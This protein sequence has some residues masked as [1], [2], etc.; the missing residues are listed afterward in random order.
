MN[1]R[2]KILAGAFGLA[3]GAVVIFLAVNTLFLEPAA[4]CDR[5]AVQEEEKIARIEAQYAR[6]D[7]YAAHLKEMAAAAFGAEE[8]R[9]AQVRMRVLEQVRTTVDRLLTLSGLSTQNLV[10]TP[11]DGAAVGGAYREI[12]W[13]VVAQGKLGQVINFLYLMSREPHLH[14]LDNIS[15]KPLAG[16]PG[17]VQLQV[18]YATLILALAKGEKLDIDALPEAPL[19]S[20]AL[21]APDRQQYEIIAARALF[22]PFIPR[23]AA[24]A[25]RPPESGG[26]E[27]RPQPPGLCLVS[28]A[29]Y[30]GQ[31]D[32][33]V[34]DSS[35]GKMAYYKLGD[36][37]A[38]GKIM[39]VDYR[40]LPSP[41]D[42]EVL[43]GSRLILRIGA[44][45]YAIEL[46]Q[47]LSQKRP[48]PAADL[49]P[50]L[51]KLQTVDP[52]P[53]SAPAGPETK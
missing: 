14:R 39:M 34:R 4:K 38:G 27:T 10:L 13:N 17:N 12:N 20:S 44:D 21:A 1:K 22:L 42:P 35:N 23:P 46:G 28:L 11:Q 30:D 53:T 15:L 49:P 19:D 7:Q 40:P 37:L 16:N 48:L 24:V 9:D 31:E 29:K 41:K 8:G 52:G 18:R 33:A 3:A 5:D 6:K 2:E 32:I 26:G 50:E 47:N 36:T 43:S 45:Y 25:T 51:P